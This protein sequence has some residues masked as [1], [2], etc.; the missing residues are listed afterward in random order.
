M[1]FVI[2]R[3]RVPSFVIGLLLLLASSVHHLAWVSWLGVALIVVSMT[4]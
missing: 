2:A 1:R 3:I 4:T